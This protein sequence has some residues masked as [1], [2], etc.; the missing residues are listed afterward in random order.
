[1]AVVY[2]TSCLITSRSRISPFQSD[3][4]QDCPADSV[5]YSGNG[6]QVRFN[7][8]VEYVLLDLVKLALL[9]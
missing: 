4:P 9:P 7:T 1:M 2:V 5:Y 8:E 3:F 6:I